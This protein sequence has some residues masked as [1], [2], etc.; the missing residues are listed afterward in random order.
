MDESSL[1]ECENRVGMDNV[2]T[3]FTKLLFSK[4]KAEPCQETI[5]TAMLGQSCP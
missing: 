4:S 3:A 2:N 1:L 5:H